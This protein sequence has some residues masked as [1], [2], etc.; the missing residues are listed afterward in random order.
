[1]E[2]VLRE[3]QEGTRS[4]VRKSLSPIYYLITI[5]REDVALVHEYEACQNLSLKIRRT[6]A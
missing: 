3:P 1:M 4:I 5:N 2:K 6:Q